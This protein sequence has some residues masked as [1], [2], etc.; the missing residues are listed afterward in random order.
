[1]QRYAAL[2]RIR[3]KIYIKYSTMFHWLIN[4]AEDCFTMMLFCVPNE[5]NC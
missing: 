4:C 5:T 3:E 2:L 1:M